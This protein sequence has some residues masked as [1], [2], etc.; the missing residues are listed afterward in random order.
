[1]SIRPE[2]VRWKVEAFFNAYKSEDG[3]VN[4]SKHSEIELFEELD[5]EFHYWVEMLPSW[6]SLD[7]IVITYTR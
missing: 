4:V 1:M 2:F 3:S 6:K 5:E 7:K